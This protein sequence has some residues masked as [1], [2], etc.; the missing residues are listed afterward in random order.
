[1]RQKGVTLV[2]LIIVV[3]IV[4]ILAGIAATS[5]YK[6]IGDTKKKLKQPPYKGDVLFV[7]QTETKI[8][9]QNMSEYPVAIRISWDGGDPFGTGKGQDS[10]INNNVADYE[11]I[12]LSFNE[13]T[14]VQVWAWDSTKALVDE[15]DLQ[16]IIPPTNQKM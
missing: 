7:Q 16:I 13:H 2:E 5:Y 6:I 12:T 11:E 10:F 14:T 9:V 1:M 15:C 8:I 3:A 4:L